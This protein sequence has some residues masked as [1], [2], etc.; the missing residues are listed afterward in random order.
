MSRQVTQRPG[1]DPLIGQTKPSYWSPQHVPGMFCKNL[2]T[3]FLFRAKSGLLLDCKPCPVHSMNSARSWLPIGCPA[4]F[5]LSHW[6][7]RIICHKC[8]IKC[9]TAHV[10]SATLTTLQLRACVAIWRPEIL[11]PD[12][13]FSLWIGNQWLWCKNFWRMCIPPFTR[14]V[15]SK[16]FVIRMTHTDVQKELKAII[17]PEHELI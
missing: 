5:W 16:E 7:V 9:T 3:H 12:K 13:Y 17:P 8:L 14:S 2:N 11:D 1:Q 15:S 4:H 6:L 10:S